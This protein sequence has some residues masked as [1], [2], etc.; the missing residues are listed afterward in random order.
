MERASQAVKSL[1]TSD[2]DEAIVEY[3]AS[4]CISAANDNDPSPL[5]EALEDCIQ[6]DPTGMSVS[7]SERGKQMVARFIGQETI[8]EPAPPPQKPGLSIKATE[9]KPRAP[10]S[11]QTKPAPA[12][13]SSYVH[14]SSQVEPEVAT[15]LLTSWFPD[16]SSSDLQLLYESLGSNLWLTVEEL[17]LM[18]GEEPYSARLNQNQARQESKQQGQS[19][20]PLLSSDRDFPSLSGSSPAPPSVSSTP[21]DQARSV[22]DALL[23]WPPAA[24]TASSSQRSEAT[25]RSSTDAFWKGGSQGGDD[26]SYKQPVAWLEGSVPVVATGAELTR[27]YEALRAEA[28][29]RMM[30]RADCYRR[31]AHAYVAGNRAQA[32]ALS[33]EAREHSDAMAAA[34]LRAA[35]AIYRSRNQHSSGSF[36]DLHGLHVKEAIKLLTGIIEER[37]MKREGGLKVCTGVGKHS[38]D[39]RERTKADAQGRLSKAVESLFHRLNVTYRELQPGLYS[40]SM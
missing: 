25:S 14:S 3:L 12:Y 6:P 32:Q 37:R 1:I 21:K 10:P 8:P 38:D 31:A 40:C 24:A 33:K 20:T 22:K 11:T 26:L 7:A 19:K 30:K 27:L 2:L 39:P 13:D 5:I 15:A 35:A 34:D 9:F 16:Y 28:R 17:Q 18:E 23:V 29:E 36:V 4:L